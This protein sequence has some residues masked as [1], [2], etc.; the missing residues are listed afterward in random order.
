MDKHYWEETDNLGI[1][2]NVESKEIKATIERGAA[3][4]DVHVWQW[5]ERK[6]SYLTRQAAIHAVERFA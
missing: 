6:K 2:V 3:M 1:Y 4:G 5:V